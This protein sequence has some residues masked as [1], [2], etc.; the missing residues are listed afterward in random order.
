MG[1]TLTGQIVAETYDS[2]LK[3]TDNNTITGT[4]KRIT[5]G[6]GNDTPLLLSS[7]DVQIDG[8][9]LLAGTISQYVRG[10][11]SFATFTDVGLTSVGITLG[12]A[13]TDAGVSGS[14]LTSNGSITLNLPSASA[15]NRGLLTATDWTT[16]NSKQ[17]ALTLTTTGSSGSSTF[18]GSTLNIPTYTLAG[19]GGVPTSRTLTINGTTFDLTANRSWTITDTG[20]TSVGVSMPS[21]FTVSN[22]P[23]TSNGTIAITGAGLASQYIR[24]DGTLANFPTTGGGGSSVSYY[25]NGSVNQG[26]ILGNVYRELNK[27]PII[28]AGTDFTINANG[29]IAQ[30]ITDANDPALLEI[31][32]GNWNFEM[33]FSASSG[34]G[35]PSF[36]VELYKYNGTTFTLIASD[37]A[38]PEG[39]T[40]GTAIDLYTTALAVPQTTLTL[41]DRLAIRVYVT[42]SGRT[43]TLHTENSHLCQVITTFST[44]IT[45]LNSLTKQVQYLTV[46]TS[47]TDFTISSATDT[48]TFNL[49]TA[50]ATNRGALSSADWTTFN[51]KV[52]TTRTISTTAPLSGGG[53]LSADRTLTISQATT[54]TD[55]YLSSTNWNTFNS[56]ESALTFSSPLS[57]STN[58]ISIPVATSSI[59]GY[60]SSTDWTTFNSKVPS[61]RTLTINGTA[62]D[63]SADRSWTIAT[64]LS[65][66]GTTNYVSKFTG[67]SSIGDSQIFDNGTNV[68][69]GTASPTQ[70]LDVNGN[71]VILGFLQAG[72]ASV[73]G[74]PS[75]GLIPTAI[76]GKSPAGVLDIRNTN[77]T[78]N[79]G[80]TAGIIQFSVK[81][82]ATPGYTVARIDVSTQTNTT[83]GNSGGG[84]IKF[85]TSVGGTGAFPT[86]R[87]RITNTGNVGIGVTVPT[88]KLDVSGAGLFS[89]SVT[90][91]SFI[92]SGGASTEL[93][94]ANGSVVTAGTNITISGGTISAAAGS[95]DFN[96]LTNK[97][98]GTGT[99]Q[100]SGD[101]RAPIFYDSNDTTYFV[102]P[103]GTSNLVGLTVANTITGSITGSAGSVAWSNIT[104]KPTLLQVNGNNETLNGVL[105]D[106][107]TYWTTS[108]TN[109]PTS[110]GSLLTVTGGIAWYN[111]LGFGTND[112]MAFR[113]S[114]NNNT[115]WTAWKTILNSSNYSAY[116]S[117]S[118]AVYGTIFYDANDT[119]YYLNPNGNSN[120]NVVGAQGR[121]YAGY[122]SG[123]QYS[124]SCS[125]WFR[126]SGGTGWYNATYAGGINMIDTTWVRV[127][128]SKAFYVENQIAAT[129]D[130]TAYYSDERLKEKKGNISNALEK[131][132]SLD[133]F[134]YI[135]NELAKSVGYTEDKLQLGLSAQQVQKIA[136]E[137]VS[138]APF[139][140][141]TLEDGT[142]VSKSGEDYLTVNYAK[143]NPIIIE[144]I[145]EQQTIINNQQVQIEELKELVNKLINK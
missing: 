136:P 70:K 97:T 69:I 98:G 143:L 23:L 35:S 13:G 53:D 8:N 118:G 94:A 134:Y 22:S 145:K 141:E 37:S 110:Y 10:D 116:S 39:I 28:G 12:S 138:L 132:L 75:Y 126:S 40:N 49:P 74:A 61:T 58:T 115:S 30:F 66:T 130:V 42:H 129:G 65:G 122:D 43:I 64:G 103:N 86:E 68:G 127:Y 137:I 1:N 84:N 117:F 107:T 52:A 92:K 76:I 95:V 81:G 47:G 125:D 11:G 27:T 6:F 119:G 142:V 104:S 48:H 114:I 62:Y 82:D 128:G 71:A 73:L 106:G 32:A 121:F 19:L 4:K 46:G 16:F 60:L 51:G 20:L 91:N 139:D 131:I 124:M 56:K 99:Y 26:T 41:T 29:Y 109:A 38:T 21:A 77:G 123:V 9:L 45:A 50:S 3:V 63:L 80:D 120:L 59:N 79:A 90:A 96:N 36:Y 102:N 140:Y 18:V 105:N 2:L 113:Q 67:T 144:A 14:P 31:P 89:S 111:Q 33:F 25:L 17:G 5:D 112:S 24:G 101:F 83:T 15:T 100:T 34:G 93:L 133:G 55:G 87:M 135:N 44:G 108:A 78:V 85:L 88:V 57:R 54:S 72:D 7:T